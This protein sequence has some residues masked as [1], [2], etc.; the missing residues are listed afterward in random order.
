[1]K[2]GGI[3]FSGKSKRGQFYLIAAVILA[4]VVIGIVTVS[5]YT[6]K[7]SNTR[8]Y[9][10][11]DELKIEGAKVIDYGTSNSLSDSQIKD[12]MQNF[13]TNYINSSSE[14]NDYFLFGTQSSVRVI[15]SQ[16]E[17][18]NATFDDGSGE[19]VLTI[20]PGKIFSQDFTPTNTT[21]KIKINDFQYNFELNKGQNFYFV[22]SQK[23]DSGTYIVTG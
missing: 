14:E 7:V 22:L 23:S 4:T 3:L 16:K 18:E 19:T 15:A 1:M 6:N 20:I 12:T 11:R 21:V 8:I 10:I 17:A 5:N 2:R 9:N 13:L